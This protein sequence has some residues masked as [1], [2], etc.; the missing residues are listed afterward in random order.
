MNEFDQIVKH[1]LKVRYYARYTDDFIVVADNEKY[2]CSTLASMRAF[3]EERLRLNLHP[4]KVSIKRY[5]QGVDFLGYVVIPYHVRLRTKTK[6][7]VMRKL[8]D[9]VMRFKRGD[10]I[11][12][13]LKAALQSY[14]GVLSHAD[15]YR[16]GEDLKN[17]F[18]WWMGE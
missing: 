1:G 4:E 14:L 9:Q 7:R 8:R 17:M 18:W 11:E 13:T 3:L 16:M 6:R 10:I 5:T 2:L 12:T 15:A